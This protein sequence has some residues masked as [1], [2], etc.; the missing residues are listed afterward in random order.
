MGCAFEYIKSG[1]KHDG[2]GVTI[3]GDFNGELLKIARESRGFSVEDLSSKTGI[4]V[5]HIMELEVG[6]CKPNEYELSSLIDFLEMPSAFF[7]RVTELYEVPN[8]IILCGKGIVPCDNCGSVADYLCDYPVGD[9]K[10]CGMRICDDCR[11][12]IGKYDFCPIHS[13]VN[14]VI[15]V[16]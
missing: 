13:E 7:Y 3:K 6:L 5:Q 4:R 9:G 14:K 12:H 11:I 16:F 8:P 10:T 15:K 1:V 2:N